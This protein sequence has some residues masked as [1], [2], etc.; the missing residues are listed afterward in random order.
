MSSFLC[1]VM[2]KPYTGSGDYYYF[3]HMLRHRKLLKKDKKTQV[4][5]WNKK[6]NS[7]SKTHVRKS[8]GTK[9]SRM[10][11]VKDSF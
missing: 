7:T 5:R 8:N 11:Q 9:Y 3:Q 2:I 4:N 6:V 10:D 1:C